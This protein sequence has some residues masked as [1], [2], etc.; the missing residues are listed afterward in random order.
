[1]P[2]QVR[3][4]DETVN[5]QSTHELTLDFLTERITVRELIRSRVY[6]EVKD[7]NVA[8]NQGDFRGLVQPA[9]AEEVL[10]DPKRRSARPIDWQKQFEVALQAF[11][12]S[13]YLILVDDRQVERLD[14]EIELTAETQVSFVKLVP[15]V[16]G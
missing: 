10:N 8:A 14:E 2:I 6:Q 4:R 12:R 13:G 3:V 9:G 11:G 15:L 16:G 7:H 1:M 5:G